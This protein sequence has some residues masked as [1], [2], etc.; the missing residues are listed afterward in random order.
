MSDVSG[1]N[2]ATT[3]PQALL[4]SSWRPRRGSTWYWL[5]GSSRKNSSCFSLNVL[6]GL[7]AETLWHLCNNYQ[8]M[9]TDE[10]W[11]VP[12]HIAQW[13]ANPNYKHDDRQVCMP[14]V[15]SKYTN[16]DTPLLARLAAPPSNDFE[17]PKRT[18]MNLEKCFT[19]R[20]HLAKNFSN[21]DLARPLHQA[22]LQ[23]NLC[24]RWVN[25]CS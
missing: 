9:T 19:R 3:M 2:P 22:S 15:S 18:T 12:F 7:Y 5:V 4:E 1:V 21:F 23:W 8:W 20:C 14:V 11:L 13:C 17:A 10:R 16:D 6:M 25:K 24:H